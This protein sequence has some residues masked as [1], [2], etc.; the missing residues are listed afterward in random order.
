MAIA[1]EWEALFSADSRFRCH[2]KEK[3]K[4]EEPHMFIDKNSA[5]LYISF[6][7]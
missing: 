5:P 4:A 3:M 1:F 6:L 2:P 7:R